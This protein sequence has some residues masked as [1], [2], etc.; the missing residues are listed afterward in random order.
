MFP[1]VE[2]PELVQ[3]YAPFFKGVF[4]AEAFIE[5]ERYVSGLIVS[6]NKTVDG[7][8]RLFVVESR[9]QSSL[10]RLLTVSPF[11]LEALNQARLEVV[12]GLPGTRM[13]P[14]GVFSVD[15]TL[16]TH[17]GQDFEQIAKLWDHVTGTYVWAHDLVTIHYSDDETDYP[18]LF[19]LWEPVDLEKLEQ[20][21]REAQIPIQA[22]KEA[23]KTS[24]PQKWRGYLL[25]VWQRRQKAHPEIRALYDSKLIIVQKLLHQWVEKHPGEKRPV[26]FDNWFTQPAFCRFLDQTLKLPY[27]GTLAETDK[28][29]LKTGQ[30]TL[31]DFAAQLKQE[32]LEALKNNGKQVFQKITIPYKG[33]RETYSSYCNTH[34]IHNFGKQ[35]LVINYRQAD[36]SDNPTF[37]ISNRLVWQAAGITRIRRHR[38]PVEVYHEEGKAEGLD[39][40]QL[41][42]FSAIQR[43]VA[44]VAV[45]YSL[46]RAA[47]HDPV[48]RERLQRQLKMK[49]EGGPAA[50]RRASQAQSLWCLGLFIS[51]G[52]TQGQSLQE[53][54]SPLLRAVCKS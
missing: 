52:L 26:T 38:W 29:N 24:D 14:N 7:I 40:Y 16:L 4:S 21:L 2:F 45:V 48:L 13:K 35:R 49:L 23:L 9:N 53:I 8:N 31:K 18:V 5:F 44:L 11:S 34:H 37:F 36:L 12:D 42:D 47:Q 54:M 6:E 17:Y 43:H 27:V 32:H 3:H 15:D 19:Q 33:E 51:A 28:V 1:L 25:G 46:L 22:S 10:N 20:G 50:W 39:Q 30:T 41:R